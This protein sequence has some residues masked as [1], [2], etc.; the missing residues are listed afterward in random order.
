MSLFGNLTAGYI[1]SDISEAID[2]FEK[3]KEEATNSLEL[4]Y[5]IKGLELAKDIARKYED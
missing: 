3:A 4:D 5:L 1:V 2:E